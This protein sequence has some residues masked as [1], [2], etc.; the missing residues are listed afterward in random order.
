M[1]NTTNRSHTPIW[2]HTWQYVAICMQPMPTSA[3]NL[4][5]PSQWRPD[6]KRRRYTSSQTDLMTTQC[7]IVR[8]RKLVAFTKDMDC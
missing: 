2:I 8:I 7:T 5:W 3:R 6:S 1:N 4:A